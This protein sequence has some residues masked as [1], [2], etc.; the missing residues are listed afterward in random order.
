MK[1]HLIIIRGNSGSGKSTLAREL[2][3]QMMEK[4]INTALVE[5]DYFRRIVLK[6]KERKNGDNI[7]LIKQT[8]LFALKRRYSVVLEGI[9]SFSRYGTTLEELRK[10][11]EQTFVYYMDIPFEETLR[12]HN[13]KPNAHE[14]GEKEMK[15]WWRERDVTNFPEEKI[16]RANDTLEQSIQS[17]LNDINSH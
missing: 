5:Q 9:L 11:S 3:L 1:Q 6:E 17:I 7:A 12:R 16:I 14:F 15:E 13:T 2:R 8:V 10:Y 4:G